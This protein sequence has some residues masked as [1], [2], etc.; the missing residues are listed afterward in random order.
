LLAYFSH[1]SEK[2]GGIGN[3]PTVDIGDARRVSHPGSINE[4]LDSDST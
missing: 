2:R 4:A 3:R 1:A